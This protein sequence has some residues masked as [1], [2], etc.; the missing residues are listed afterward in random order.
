MSEM[1]ERKM[2]TMCD[3]PTDCVTMRDRR[4]NECWC[5]NGASN[6]AAAAAASAAAALVLV[7]LLF[8]L[9]VVAL[10]RA[11]ALVFS[12]FLL[13]APL[14]LE[15]RGHCCPK[16]PPVHGPAYGKVPKVGG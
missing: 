15:T 9:A 10:P 5:C 16:L 11:L 13:L 6:L 2:H 8:L 14:F 4:Y 3:G 7:L 12:F 1:C